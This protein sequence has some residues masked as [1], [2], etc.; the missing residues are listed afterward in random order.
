MSEYKDMNEL[1]QYWEENNAYPD[2]V[3]GIWSTNGS[4]SHLTVSL[5]DINAQKEILELIE[6]DS[7]V[8]FAYGKYSKNYLLSIIDEMNN[9]FSDY[10]YAQNTGFVCMG[11][12]EYNNCIDISFKI[13]FKENADTIELT[14]EL[15]ERFADAV[16]IDYT[17]VVIENTENLMLYP[18]DCGMNTI[19]YPPALENEI[20]ASE[21]DL[22]VSCVILTVSVL[23][24]L[25]ALIFQTKRTL[26]LSNGE[27][28]TL[29]HKND[30]IES[31]LKNN[32]PEPSPELDKKIFDMIDK[33]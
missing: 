25:T 15:N 31:I 28:S 11:L 32:S 24:L 6:I 33:L 18:D 8:A 10:E 30:D 21:N 13:G 9:R 22:G 16:Y 2:Y 14:A 29:G 4:L 26:I 12:N 17:D 3:C 7:S 19:V 5:N 1:F 23:T 27:T 20:K